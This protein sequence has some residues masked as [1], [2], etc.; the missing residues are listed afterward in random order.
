M[1]RRQ[2]KVIK[3]VCI[4]IISFLVSICY[5]VVTC[6]S[7]LIDVDLHASINTPPASL[8]QK[9]QNPGKYATALNPAL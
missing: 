2:L 3:M 9:N 1:N 8:P 6:K 5:T 7:Y 4:T